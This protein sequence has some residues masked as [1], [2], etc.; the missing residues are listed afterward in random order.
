MP[1]SRRQDGRFGARKDGCICDGF[2]GCRKAFYIGWLVTSD[3]T[4]TFTHQNNNHTHY[5][6]K[7]TCVRSVQTLLFIFCSCL[8][9]RYNR[10]EHG[11]PASSGT[12][13]DLLHSSKVRFLEND[14][15]S[16]DPIST[17][18]VCL[19][20]TFAVVIVAVASN[21]PGNCRWPPPPMMNM[22]ALGSRGRSMVVE[23]EAHDAPLLLIHPRVV[24]STPDEEGARSIPNGVG[25]ENPLR[26][27]RQ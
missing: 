21:S 8:H 6:L 5:T 10:R 20:R 14:G 2:F 12:S 11:T 16:R 19:P 26:T 1:N 13:E 18:D 22:A 7:V 23:A 15:E 4:H 17:A 9:F 3:F 25:A 24:V 27:S